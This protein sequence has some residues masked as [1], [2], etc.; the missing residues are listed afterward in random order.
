MIKENTPISMP[1]AA[2]YLKGS[3]DEGKE[4]VAFIKKFNSLK[5]EKAKELRVKLRELSLVKLNEESISK[6]IDLLPSTN[7]EINKVVSNVGLDEEEIQK[8]IS[9]IKEYI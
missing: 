8:V 6:L 4:M 7:E 3:K 9:A 1:E 2:A 5:P